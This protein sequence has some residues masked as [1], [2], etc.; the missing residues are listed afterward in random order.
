MEL[1]FK[2][3]SEKIIKAA[4]KVY[5]T[6]GY[7][8][9]E[10]EYQKAFAL[11]LKASGLVFTQELYSD[12][13]YE[14]VKIRGFFVDF[15]VEDGGKK[16][17]VEIKVASRPHQRNFYQV[18]QYLKNYNLSLGLIIVFSPAGVIIKRVVNLK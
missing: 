13:F 5:N 8:Y 17:V 4:F 10:K 11:E 15:L 16:I 18:F 6:L 9:Q 12:L 3:L 7:G 14:G 2:D 1:I